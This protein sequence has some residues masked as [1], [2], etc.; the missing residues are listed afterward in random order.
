MS[1]TAKAR[2]LAG[3]A[4]GLLG[5]A[6]A[7][8]VLD[9]FQQA[10]IKTTQKAEWAL[11][12]RPRFSEQQKAQL[13]GYAYAHAE[14]ATRLSNVLT[15]KDLTREQKDQAIPYMHYLF[16]A[17]AGAAYGLTA[18][19]LPAATSGFGTTF[20]SLLFLGAAETALPLLE[21]APSP[22][23]VPPAM[24]VGGLAAHAV[25]G[26]ALEGVRRLTRHLF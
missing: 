2:P 23:R 8:F 16:G 12:A 25:Y 24:H 19:Y 5:G 13:R 17:L 26:A 10:S 6:V 20:G 7:T 22:R 21:L 11:N 14:S 18:E 1:P 3:L 9:L 15:G 4:A